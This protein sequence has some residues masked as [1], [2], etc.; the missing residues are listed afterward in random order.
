MPSVITPCG[1][2]GGGIQ[3]DTF[4]QDGDWLHIGTTGT[5]EGVP[6]GSGIKLT[7]VG[8][9]NINAQ[10]NIALTD[11]GGGGIYLTSTAGSKGA[12]YIGLESDGDLFLDGNK[13]VL[14]SDGANIQ[15]QRGGH[16]WVIFNHDQGVYMELGVGESFYLDSVSAG[17]LL[18]VTE[19]GTYHIRTGAVWVDDL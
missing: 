10:N 17:L 12:G 15:M 9:I 6:S 4:P 5:R 18:Q 8:R 14:Q 2:G 19:D 11:T 16:D 7:A 1:G 13:I 3:F